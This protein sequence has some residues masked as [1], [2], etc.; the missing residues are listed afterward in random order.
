MHYA[1]LQTC[2][3]FTTLTSGPLLTIYSTYTPSQ[4]KPI[5]LILHTGY[6]TQAVKI[7][8]RRHH[9]G[10][11]HWHQWFRP[12]KLGGHWCAKVNVVSHEQ[13]LNVSTK[14]F[15]AH[16]ASPFSVIRMFLD[17]RFLRLTATSGWTFP[18]YS[19]N[20]VTFSH[21]PRRAVRGCT[22]RWHMPFRIQRLKHLHSISSP[23][24]RLAPLAITQS[25]LY[26]IPI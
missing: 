4:G 6:A 18:V 11:P 21:P 22:V 25:T 8:H 20:L 16:C 19:T 14:L 23:N 24:I 26:P 10:T 1:F 17:N 15:R 2:S 5:R 7:C 3:C 9:C 12:T 13:P